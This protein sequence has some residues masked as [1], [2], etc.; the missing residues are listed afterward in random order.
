MP[1]PAQC[2]ASRNLSALRKSNPPATSGKLVAAFALAATASGLIL[3]RLQATL[4]VTP[5]KI[6][7]QLRAGG[8]D[9]E[10]GPRCTAWEQQQ[11]CALHVL[12]LGDAREQLTVV[13]DDL[14]KFPLPTGVPQNG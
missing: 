5:G 10:V 1:T 3:N 6:G 9:V 2:A 4:P 11:P 14:G 8:A 13:R 12:H 7:C